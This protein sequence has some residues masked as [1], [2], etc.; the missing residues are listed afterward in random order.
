MTDIEM[1]DDSKPVAQE[2]KKEDQ[3]VEEPTDCFYG[4]RP[5]RAFNS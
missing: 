4:K 5:L 2:D 3:K 1:K